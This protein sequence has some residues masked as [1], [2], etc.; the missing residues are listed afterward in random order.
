[1]IEVTVAFLAGL[2]I[3]S[4]LNVCIYRLPRDL[5][6]VRPRSFCP[7][8]EK[9]IAWYDNIPIVS[10][11]VLRG[12]CRHCHQSIPLRYPLVELATSFLFSTA[13][14]QW[15]V[16][17]LAIKFC[18][19][20]AILVGLIGA[21][22]E[23]R[24][25]PDEF[26]I[27]GIVLGLVFAWFVPLTIGLGYLFSTFTRNLHVLSLIESVLGAL[28]SSGALWLV[29]E[30][31]YRLRKREGLGLGDVKMVAMIGAFL[32]LQGVLLTV[33]AA[34]LLGGI[35]GLIY[36]LATGKNASTYQL[37]FGAF[38]GLSGLII[39]VFGEAIIRWYGGLGA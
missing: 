19:F 33:I 36:I 25:L 24:I 21:D 32:G 26:T 11:L 4:F 20:S 15:G 28:V 8:C 7:A 30:V 16:S 13:V 37:P 2:L 9:Q 10:F 3:G 18:V 23:E 17:V 27:G 34:S 22:L 6:V 14:F 1:M 39:G 12:R 35:G 38:L 31:Y 5:S 29:G